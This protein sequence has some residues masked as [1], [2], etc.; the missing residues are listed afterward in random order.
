M[1]IKNHELF[2]EAIKWVIPR[3]DKKI[4]GFV[5]GDGE[6]RTHLEEYCREIGLSYSDSSDDD[7][8]IYF[9]SWVKNVDY[10][11]S[12]SDIIALTSKNEGTPV[13]LIEAQA[14]NKSIVTTRVGGIEDVVLSNQTAL[15][16]DLNSPD[17]F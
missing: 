16:S 14:G 12:G 1:P 8:D 4:K 5:V 11:N 10:V 9:T 13:S 7:V 15:L 6:S 17:Q 3:L 2:F